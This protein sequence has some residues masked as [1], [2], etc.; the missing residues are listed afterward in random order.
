MGVLLVEDDPTLRQLLQIVVKQAGIQAESVGGDAALESIRSE[1]FDAIVL[2]V[3]LSSLSGL[4]T[5]MT[6]SE[7]H[8][9][10]LRR[11][12]VLTALSRSSLR[13]SLD[14]P[15]LWDVI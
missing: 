7:T 1:K 5:I 4:R 9:H 14:A 6:L 11:I 8:P 3:A 13:D 12:I 10:L 15:S 2:D